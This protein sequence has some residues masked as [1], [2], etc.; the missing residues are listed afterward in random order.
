[1]KKQE[2]LADQ[3]IWKRLHDCIQK[4][5]LKVGSSATLLKVRRIKEGSTESVRMR[6]DLRLCVHTDM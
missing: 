2:C 6:I 5:G 1:M 4:G 3:T